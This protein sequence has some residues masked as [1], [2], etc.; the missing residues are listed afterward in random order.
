MKFKHGQQMFRTISGPCR[1]EPMLGKNQ[2]PTAM[3][4]N[5]SLVTHRSPP[6]G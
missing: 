3:G 4:R 1:E 5:K 2:W 6:A